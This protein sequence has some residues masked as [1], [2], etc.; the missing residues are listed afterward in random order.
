[1]NNDIFHNIIS[2]TLK[3]QPTNL[4]DD[5]INFYTIRK[6]LFYYYDN[7]ESKYLIFIDLCIY[8]SEKK[9]IISFIKNNYN[10]ISTVNRIL[11]CLT[12][13]ERLEFLIWYN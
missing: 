3:P 12:T 1:M 13:E 11:G 6:I 7:D 8:F 9:K 5:I 10:I 2:Y 4:L